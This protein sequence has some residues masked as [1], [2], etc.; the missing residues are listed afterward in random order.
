MMR[1]QT[2][3]VPMLLLVLTI[4]IDVE[5]V[6]SVGVVMQIKISLLLLLSRGWKPME[7]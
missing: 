1:F 3:I 7:E 5:S 4:I 6:E 2:W